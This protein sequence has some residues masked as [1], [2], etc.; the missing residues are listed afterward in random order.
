[1]TD[2]PA[3]RPGVRIGIDIGSVRVG[4]ARSDPAG[5]L[6]VPVATLD[7]RAGDD[8]VL[9]RIEDLVHEHEALEVL[10]GHPLS[11]S[12]APGQAAL[13]AQAFA[14]LLADR[15]P[16]TAV[17]LVDERLSTVSAQRSLHE[18]GRT[19][20]RSRSVIDQQAAVIVVQHALDSER[21]G[22]PVGATVRR[23]DE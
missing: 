9:G 6:A 17:R 22:G 4:V 15:L 21:V 13:A 14:Q 18:A 7:R 12:G 2:G 3:V 20:R 5:T 19:H 23:R 16:A 1:M 8:V 10:V 11:L